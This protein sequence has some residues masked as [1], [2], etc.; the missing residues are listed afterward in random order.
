MDGISVCQCPTNFY[1][2]SCEILVVNTRNNQATIDTCLMNNC[3]L[4]RN[5]NRCDHECNFAQ[6]QFDNYECTLK[7]DPWDLCSINDC[8]RLFR[9]GKCD[10]KCNIKECLLD[11]FDCD[12]QTTSTC[13]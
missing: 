6:C 12:R 1:G 13:K 5:N 3:S 11:G 9:N 10:E 8:W 4:K 7:R 2:N